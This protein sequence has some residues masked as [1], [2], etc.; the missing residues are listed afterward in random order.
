MLARANAERD[1]KKP[2]RTKRSRTD[3]SLRIDSDRSS[4]WAGPP[5]SVV[6]LSLLPACT[7][8]HPVCVRRSCRGEAARGA[9]S[10]FSP[11][12]KRRL[13][14]GHGILARRAFSTCAR[15][16]ANHSTKVEGLS[17]TRWGSPLRYLRYQ[18]PSEDHK[19]KSSSLVAGGALEPEPVSAEV[20]S[21][22]PLFFSA[23]TRP[24]RKSDTPSA[25]CCARV[26][27][28]PGRHR[29]ETVSREVPEA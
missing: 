25:A 24:G 9:E 2:R 20:R 12:V 8:Q 5:R 6:G 14:D 1:A 17:E 3:P 11:E 18:T 26:L 15:T 10:R 13:P 21:N 22:M 7:S 29:C 19:E 16:R 23:P 27:P 28:A 4:R